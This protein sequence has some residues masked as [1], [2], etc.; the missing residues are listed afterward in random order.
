MHEGKQVTIDSSEVAKKDIQ[1]IIHIMTPETKTVTHYFWIVAYDAAILEKAPQF[2]QEL[3]FVAAG[4]FHED[5]VA[6]E[7]IEQLVAR[8]HRPGFREKIL[9]T[10]AGGMQ[11]LRLVARWAAEE[12]T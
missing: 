7:S 3:Q 2:S 8:D 9:K 11:V 6:L 4:A 12:Q 1:H 10:D 5:K